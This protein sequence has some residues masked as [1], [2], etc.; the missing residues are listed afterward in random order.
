MKMQGLRGEAPS[1][2]RERE[3]GKH[4]NP[5]GNRKESYFCGTESRPFVQFPEIK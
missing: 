1:L 5:R 2:R 3:G 4:E